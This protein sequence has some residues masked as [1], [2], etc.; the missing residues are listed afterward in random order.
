LTLPVGPYFLCLCKE[1]RQRKHTLVTHFRYAKVP[2]AAHVLGA[3]LRRGILPR[4]SA[5]DILVRR[6]LRA[7]RCSVRHKGTTAQAKPSCFLLSPLPR[8]GEG[9]PSGPG[10][11][12]LLRSTTQA[13]LSPA[14][15]RLS[16]ARGR[17][18]QQQISG[19]AQRASS[20]RCS[21][22]WQRRLKRRA[23]WGSRTGRPAELR[24]DTMSRRSDPEHVAPA[25]DPFVGAAV[26]RARTSG[27]AFSCLLLFARAKRSMTLPRFDVHQ[28]VDN[29][30]MN[31]ERDGQEIV[32]TEPAVHG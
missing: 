27:R 10:E 31:G 26:E 13:P 19:E 5:A 29:F 25:G 22:P 2:C 3:T 18:E 17:E 32:G 8:A 14:S 23:Q 9:G 12:L 1:S 7:L 16:P 15:Q 20:S 30:L 6:P 28:N 11:G 24:R 4:R 21:T